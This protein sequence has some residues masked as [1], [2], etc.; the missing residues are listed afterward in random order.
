MA[1]YMLTIEIDILLYI[2]K[3]D[4]IHRKR[5]H[6]LYLRNHISIMLTFRDEVIDTEPINLLLCFWRKK[7]ANEVEVPRI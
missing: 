2:N 3:L 7:V 5:S 6:A 1:V 4:A